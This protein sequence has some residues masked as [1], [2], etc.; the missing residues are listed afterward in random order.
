ML[1]V[2]IGVVV[3]GFTDLSTYASAPGRDSAAAGRWP[4]SSRIERARDRPTVVAVLHAYCPCSRASAAELGE[5]IGRAP[6]AAL[7][8]VLLVAPA[9]TGAHATATATARAAMGIHGAR[10]RVD[11][12]GDE[13]RRFGART[14]GATFVYQPDGR[15][16]FSGGVTPRRGHGGDSEGR[17]AILA[18]LAHRPP[19]TT[20]SATYGCPTGVTP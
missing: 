17:R 15:L 7:V 13:A 19:L 6:G 4:A 9:G 11:D 5:I 1:V 12:G 3:V 8:H 2:W 18:L 10:V 20:R 16:A 14:S